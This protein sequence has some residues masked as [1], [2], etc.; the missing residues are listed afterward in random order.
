MRDTVLA[1]NLVQDTLERALRKLDLWRPDSDLR[2]WLFTLIHNL[3]VNHVR[4]GIAS[5]YMYGAMPAS[6]IRCFGIRSKTASRCSTGSTAIWVM[7]SLARLATAKCKPWRM[8]RIG[9]SGIES[10]FDKGG[11]HPPCPGCQLDLASASSFFPRQLDQA[12]GNRQPIRQRFC[13]LAGDRITAR[14]RK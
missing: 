9:R 14:H 3:F 4:S 2:A 11:T 8:R 10:G 12:I 6:R 13:R 5:P 7:P 1:D